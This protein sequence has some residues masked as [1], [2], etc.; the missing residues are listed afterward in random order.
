MQTSK[1][2]LPRSSANALVALA[3]YSTPATRTNGSSNLCID[4][5]SRILDIDVFDD[6]R[7]HIS[8][9]AHR[10][11]RVISGVVGEQGRAHDEKVI[12][13]PHL[14]VLIGYRIARVG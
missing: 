9:R 10:A 8:D 11:G 5:F 13:A 1:D 12:H 4:Q 14:A 3:P 7:G 6:V 2:F